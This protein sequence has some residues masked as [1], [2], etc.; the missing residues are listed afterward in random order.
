MQ[1]EDDPSDKDMNL[2]EIHLQKVMS[3]KISQDNTTVN[4]NE[5][6]QPTVSL[7]IFSITGSS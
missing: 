1:F 2:S 6:G 7:P 3:V 4:Y 5:K